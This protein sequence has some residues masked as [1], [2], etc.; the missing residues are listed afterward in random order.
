MMYVDKLVPGA[1][2]LDVGSG[3]GYLLT[4]MGAM[5]APEIA[6]PELKKD[7]NDSLVGSVT[8]T[9]STNNDIKH[10]GIAVGV[11]HIARLVESANANIAKDPVGRRL[12]EAKV[13][14]NIVV[15][16]Q[17]MSLY[18]YTTFTPL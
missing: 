16:H 9:T 10:H 3:S 14:K 18:I 11:D 13:I 8:D 17:H 7:N 15:C 5:V 2:A 6:S 12:L 1:A 4:C